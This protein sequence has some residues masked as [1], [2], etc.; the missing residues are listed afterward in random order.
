M[1]LALTG[2]SLTSAFAIDATIGGSVP[3]VNYLIVNTEKYL[4]FSS[5]ATDLIVAEI[6]VT[7]NSDEWAV[8]LSW[9]AA[10]MAFDFGGTP[11]NIYTDLN[12]IIPNA[13]GV[14]G[15]AM[16]TGAVVADL[17]WAA[18]ANVFGIGIAAAA[19]ATQGDL[20]CALWNGVASANGDACAGT[21]YVA[22]DAIRIGNVTEVTG[23][24]FGTAFT[25]TTA[26]GIIQIKAS[27]DAG[28]ANDYTAAHTVTQTALFAGSYTQ[29]LTALVRTTL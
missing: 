7:S 5:P 13:L 4:D 17:D 22:D 1:A 11:L 14:N 15:V 12:V 21:P 19:T 23:G 25:G 6:L 16:T 20:Q 9:D 28:L 24:A 27:W 10:A 29:I 18:T 2:L 8:D 26:N 3:A